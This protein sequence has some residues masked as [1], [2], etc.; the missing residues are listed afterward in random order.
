MLKLVVA[1]HA[2]SEWNPI[3]R[4]QGLLDPPL[5][6]RGRAQAE[7]LAKALKGEEPAIVYTSPLRRTFQT[8]E[9]IS[10]RLGV[11]LK[12]DRRIIEIDHGRWS[13]LLVEEVKERYPEEF[14]MWLREP[15][16]VS[17][18][19]GESLGDVYDRVSSFLREV[20]E[21]HRGGTVVVVSHTVPIRC[22]YC[23]L[24]R[25]DLS[26]F[27]S[28]GC[29]NASYSVI[30]MEGERNVFQRLNVTCHLG[31]LYVEAHKAL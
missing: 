8:A 17:F 19:G 22:M 11:P 21:T 14:E 26:R 20:E 29:D 16:R 30:L 28:F 4:Y 12:E 18:E 1:R 31:D 5:T 27:W 10:E 2:E 24:L 7:L 25:V 23:Y 9:V 6:E 15:Q 3:G 13:G